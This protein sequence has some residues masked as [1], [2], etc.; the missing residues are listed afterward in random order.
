MLYDPFT[1]NPFRMNPS[2][3][4]IIKSQMR[5]NQNVE[6]CKKVN[7]FLFAFKYRNISLACEKLGYRRSY[8]YFWLNRLKQA[9]LTSSPWRNAPEGSFLIPKGLLQR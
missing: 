2:V 4:K 6:I 3:I 1:V 5:Y 8:F 7:L 9:N